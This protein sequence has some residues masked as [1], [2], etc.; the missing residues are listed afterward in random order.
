MKELLQH[1]HLV[2]TSILTSLT[3]IYWY[4]VSC[5]SVNRLHTMHIHG[6]C[7]VKIAYHLYFVVK[8]PRITFI[9]SNQTV[10]LSA[11]N[12]SFH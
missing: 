12:I 9:S 7:V 10:N 2:V 1:N 6:I 5:I 8:N 4:S 11:N 3:Y